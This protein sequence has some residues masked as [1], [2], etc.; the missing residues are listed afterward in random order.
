MAKPSI[1]HAERSIPVIAPKQKWTIAGII[2]VVGFIY[3]LSI[4]QTDA[5][6][7]R[8]IDGLPIIFH[9]VVDDLIPP[10][11]A[12]YK[13]AGVSLLETWN[14]ALL[15]TTLAAILCLP[16]S[17][18]MAANINRFKLFYNVV[19]FIMNIWRTI[20]DLVIAVIFVGL[21]GIGAMAGTLALAVFSIGILAKLLSETIEAIDPG[22]LEAIRSSGGNV[23]QVIW[24]G[25]MPQILPHYASYSLYV[26]EINVRASIVLGFVGAGGIGLVLRQQLNMFRYDN[27]SMIIFMTF[28]AVTIIDSVSTRLRERLV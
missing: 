11:W 26:L 4:W 6:P 14:M 2:L 5:D 13:S 22:P 27:V 24:Y 3:Y 12:Y 28:L 9:F 20:P 1:R 19:R 21:V 18:L 8:V 16:F 25:V 15:S 7:M 10:N 17:Y 23:L